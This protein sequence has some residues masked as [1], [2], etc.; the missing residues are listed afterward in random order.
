MPK[1]DMN[2]SKQK[3]GPLRLKLAVPRSLVDHLVHACTTVSI[4]WDASISGVQ[5]CPNTR[6]FRSVWELSL[7]FPTSVL[8]Y[9]FN[10]S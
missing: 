4:F 8:I 5:G 3:L 2:S 1:S 6:I 7:H 9:M 10:E